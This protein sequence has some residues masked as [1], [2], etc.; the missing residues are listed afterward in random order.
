MDGCDGRVTRGGM[1]RVAA[2]AG[3]ALAGGAALASRGGSV[4]EAA[5]SAAQNARLLNVFLLLERL[6]QRFYAGALERGALSGELLAFA[7]ATERQEAAHVGRL[8]ERLGGDVD[9]APDADFTAALSSSQ[10]F[11]RAAIALE[12]ATLAAYIAHGATLTR[13][14]VATIV[15][16]ISVE[17]RQAAWIRDLAGVDPAPRAADPPRDAQDVLDGLRDEG[18]LR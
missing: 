15:P 10:R 13:E 6:Q 18:L 4:S 3:A 17:A 12:E 16:I 11:G 5:P 7:S 2:G 1:V 9:P 14:A 8:T